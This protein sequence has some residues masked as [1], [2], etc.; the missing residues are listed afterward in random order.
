M[1]LLTTHCGYRDMVKTFTAGLT[2]GLF[3]AVSQVLSSITASLGRD[4]THC[5]WDW[6]NIYQ[7]MPCMYMYFHSYLET[8]QKSLQS[9]LM[10][11]SHCLMVIMNAGITVDAIHTI[12]V[13]KANNFRRRV[14]IHSLINS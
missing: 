7:V 13:K 11:I 10:S 4:F 8:M 14:V 9:S 12:M 6:P 3:S 1:P 5:S 2:T